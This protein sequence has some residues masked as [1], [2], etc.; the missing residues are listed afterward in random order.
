MSETI[1]EV[2]VKGGVVSDQAAK[3]AAFAFLID[4]A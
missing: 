3:D 1:V 2:L 4:P